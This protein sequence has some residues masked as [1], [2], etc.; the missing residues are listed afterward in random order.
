MSQTITSSEAP[1]ASA[2]DTGLVQ[3]E[4]TRFGPIEIASDHIIR[5]ADGLLGFPQ[6]VRFALIQ[7]DDQQSAEAADEG[8]CVFWLQSLDDP[9]LAFVVCDPTAFVADFGIDQ[10]PLR[11]DGRTDLGLAL[12]SDINDEPLQVLAIC[13]RVDEWLTGNL[14]GPLVVN[15]EKFVGKQIVLTEKRWGTRQPLIRL[16]QSREAGDQT[17]GRIAPDAPNNCARPPRWSRDVERA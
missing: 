6:S 13:N 3:I 14:L 16:G 5:F 2:T 15:V 12:E 9:R 11:E 10:I 8:G 17:A 1:T 4:T 7:A